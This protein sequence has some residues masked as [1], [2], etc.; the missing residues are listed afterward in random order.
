MTDHINIAIIGAVSAGK[1]TFTNALFIEQYS[2]MKIKR[3]TAL[4][5]IYVES[6]VKLSSKSKRAILDRNI[7]K[8][9]KLMS[10][11]EG[12]TKLTIENVE[13]IT[14]SVPKLKNFVSVDDVGFTIHDIP[15]I[16]DSSSKTVYYE[17]VRREFHRYDI[18]MMIVD[19]NS[20]F[21]TSD[22][23]EILEMILTEIKNNKSKTGIETQLMIL[24]NKADDMEMGDGGT[25]IPSCEELQEMYAQAKNIINSCKT[26]IIPELVIRVVPISAEDAFIYRMYHNN[27]KVT[28]PKKHMDKLGVNEYGKS[29]WNR[30]SHSEKASALKAL[31]RTITK[32]FKEHM[33]MSGFTTMTGMLKSILKKNNI[34]TYLTN[35]IKYELSQISEK[36]TS[37]EIAQV[38]VRLEVRRKDYDNILTRYC[39]V[40]TRTQLTEMNIV[41]HK[42][43]I[44]MDNYAADAAALNKKLTN[45][46]G[47]E[48]LSAIKAS[49]LK[50]Q[51]FF[52]HASSQELTDVKS[53]S[54]LHATLNTY[55]IS[56]LQNTNSS[57]DAFFNHLNALVENGFDISTVLPDL[58]D[59]IRS[60]A[61]YTKP[62]FDTVG[63]WMR[64]QKNGMSRSAFISALIR[65]IIIMYAHDKS[66][67]TMSALLYWKGQELKFDT[68]I[69]EEYIRMGL[70]ANEIAQGG[71]NRYGAGPTIGRAAA[72]EINRQISAVWNGISDFG[73]PTLELDRYV[74]GVI[75]ND[76]P[77]ALTTL[78]Q[79]QMEANRLAK[80]L[81]ITLPKDGKKNDNAA[82]IIT[83]GRRK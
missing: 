35:H 30:K 60:Y 48:M 31:T 50:I 74:A 8:N 55:S 61:F 47:Y 81:K 7:A 37:A 15:G 68:T 11:T 24:F 28:L 38:M 23:V 39:G 45:T 33:A 52:R 49:F 63:F 16:N 46:A 44:C 41:G 9:T 72:D 83:S 64:I 29:R 10:D 42:M 22:E 53:E 67:C 34:Y 12:D 21:N 58:L 5:Q 1:S 36:N 71:V 18:V 59:N 14:Y 20:A 65:N 13:E 75:A 40:K 73:P 78:A 2:D 54:G 80:R 56:E 69:I 25:Y 32:D 51:K 57:A 43:K 4:P 79:L 3:T 76:D 70:H 17:Y 82:L 66:K 6:S 27:P 77:P 26:K 62:D 19:I